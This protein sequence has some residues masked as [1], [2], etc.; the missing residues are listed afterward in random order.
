MGG[1]FQPYAK[2]LPGDA[3]LSKVISGTSRINVGL[4]IAPMST[5][6]PEPLTESLGRIFVEQ[7]S[8]VAGKPS[9]IQEAML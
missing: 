1:I 3:R 7:R 4:C 5:P 2:W 9:K 8:I 6:L